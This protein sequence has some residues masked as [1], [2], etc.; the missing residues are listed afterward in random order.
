M[1]GR[2]RKRG[3][4]WRVGVG[5]REERLSL[6]G[7]IGSG[8]CEEALKDEKCSPAVNSEEAKVVEERKEKEIE[9]SSM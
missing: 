5:R 7:Y 6:W 3:G 4:R 8:R 1:G 2:K 9:D